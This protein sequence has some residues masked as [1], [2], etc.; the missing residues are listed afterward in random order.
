VLADKIWLGRFTGVKVPDGYMAKGGIRSLDQE[1]YPDFEELCKERAR[2]DEE[3]SVWVSGQTDAQLAAPL[4]MVR[5][6]KQEEAPLWWAA[7]HL[8][9][10]QTH[11][12][13]QI[14]TLLTQM[15]Y[16]VGVTD[17]YAMLRGEDA[18]ARLVDTKTM[19]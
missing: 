12:R 17:F 7:V 4:L 3:I 11:H 14:T 2:T 10:H 13:G 9:N 8:F 6:G 18:A 1:L 5:R 16:D 19:T 15:G